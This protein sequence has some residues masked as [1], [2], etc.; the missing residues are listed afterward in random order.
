MRLTEP[1]FNQIL[2]N[3][4]CKIISDSSNRISSPAANMEC[5]VVDEPEK[6]YAAQA[7]ES[8]VIITIHSFRHRLCDPDGIAG[9]WAIDAIVKSGL[10]SDDSAQEI[11]E[12]RFK[13]TKIK[14]KELE[15][16]LIQI[17][18]VE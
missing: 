16:T 4:H 8:P 3:G 1:E 17:K 14:T 13:Q 10:L 5:G 12:V 7:F 18:E 2:K 6:P 9:K 11:E 15:K